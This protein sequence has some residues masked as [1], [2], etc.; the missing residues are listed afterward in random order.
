[1]NDASMMKF[2]L[3]A[4]VR[5]KED[6]AFLTGRGRYV[7]DITPEETLHA[8]V[9]RSP[10][11]HANIRIGDL[12]AAR[13]APGVHL[14][15]TGDDVAEYGPIP[16]AR[17]IKQIDGSLHDV[18]EF[19]LLVRD[20][21]R[22]VGDAIA[23]VVADS[24]NL[25]KSAAELIEVDFE[26]LEVSADIASTL[27]AGA[28]LVWPDRSNNLAYEA[29]I[30]DAEK[31][32]AA[33]AQAERTCRLSL[34]NNRL[35]A[36]YME[37][38]GCVAEYDGDADHL[39]LT[40]A[41]QGVHSIRAVIADQILRIPQEKLRLVTP[42][43]GGGFGTK[44]F[45]Y[46]EYPLAC[47]AARQLGRPVKWI[48]ERTEHFLGDSHGRDNVTTAEMAMD[49]DGRFIGL[50]I[51][52]VANLGAYI[53]PLGAFVPWLGATMSTGVYDI[54][55]AYIRIR[56]VYTN[57][58][59]VDAYRGAGR[60]EAA[61]LVER[62]VD[63]CARELCIGLD[64][65]RR[66]NFIA[67]ESFPYAT[68][69]G[70]TYDVGEF[71]GHLDQAQIAADWNGFD[72]RLAESTSRGRYRGIGLASYVEACAFAGS[73][74]AEIRLET[75][76]SLSI[77]IGTMSNG[78]GHA[79]AYGQIAAAHFGVSLEQVNLVQGDTAKLATG[80]GTG[81][82]R[83]I[84]LGL[85]SVDI[86]SRA[87]AEQVKELASERLEASVSDLELADGVVR[88]AGTDQTVSLAELAQ[89][90]EDADTL[91]ADG[92]FHQ[93]EATYPNGTHV[94]ELEIDPETGIVEILNY[95]IVDDFGVVVNP[96]LLKGQVHGGVVQG[97]GQALMENIVYD[98]DG[99]LISASFMDYAMPRAADMP[100]MSF[101][102]RNVP[103]TNN[104][105]GIKGAGEAG[106]IGATPAVMNAVCDALYRACGI[107]HID[108][109]ATP[110]RV[111][112]A[113]RRSDQS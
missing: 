11:A 109:P 51:D 87:L 80:G 100:F 45:V 113:I 96:L 101:D 112:E 27:D 48:G 104:A 38:R 95:T 2:G 25:A 94:C 66:R 16:C 81:G 103:S 54:D 19:P 82:S 72:A 97:I 10:M 111:W 92:V 28:P 110:Q 49:A 73:E 41:T 98:E 88:V 63:A 68:P 39:T 106:T 12:E 9:L 8:Y 93:D 34:I 7:G 43:V 18:P 85:P 55:A 17:P 1:M 105:M 44:F 3:G 47:I 36:N 90:A 50:R 64:E 61:F 75:D 5:R 22:F 99:Q 20:R 52:I 42:D 33:F 4:P 29:G 102:T 56:G 13:S 32:D 89:T 21:V 31:A 57:T 23:F 70:R 74:G 83:S 107:T 108:M 69:G 37:T 65:I 71:A 53:S 78:Q 15:L 58:A 14:V 79:T 26:L 77:L 46:R 40:V 30:G 59:P 6:P 86:A 76:G 60:P 67:P 84:P 35:V 62:L 91:R 24:V